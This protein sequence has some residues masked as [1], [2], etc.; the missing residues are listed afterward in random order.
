MA[1]KLNLEIDK[2]STFSY[3]IIYKILDPDTNLATVVDL[4]GYTARLQ[5]RVSISAS[6]VLKELTTEN[7]GISI[8]A[9]DG[10]ITLNISATDTSAIAV[11]SAIYDLE[12]INGSIVKRLVEGKVKFKPEVTR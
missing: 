8:T 9:L 5:M 3:D 6:T 1:T 4:T 2:G 7:G 10:K 12:L 11:D